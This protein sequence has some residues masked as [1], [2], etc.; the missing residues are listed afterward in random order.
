MKNKA[1]SFLKQLIT[2]IVTAIKSKSMVVKTKTSSLKTRLAIFNLLHNKKLLSSA[3]NHKIHA[4][5]GQDKNDN[6]ASSKQQHI[7][8]SK[9]LVLYKGDQ[10]YETRENDDSYI[11]MY[12]PSF[13]ESF[14]Y[15]EG[16]DGDDQ[17]EE[18]V[19]GT[20]SVIDMVKGSKEDEGEEFSLEDEINHVADVF[21]KRFHHQMKMQKLESFKRYQEML[22]RSV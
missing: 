15:E 3:I 16:V 17:D 9:A 18:I 11:D 1:T 20:A 21:I 22:E 5:M 6:E 8:Y 19:N 7:D 2:T 10:K 4:I 13:N 14:I 12:S